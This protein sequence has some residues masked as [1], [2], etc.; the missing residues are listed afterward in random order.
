MLN[1][2][3]RGNYCYDIG[4]TDEPVRDWR[5]RTAVRQGTSDGG[6]LPFN[7]DQHCRGETGSTRLQRTP[8]P[9]CWGVCV[10][11]S[12]ALIVVCSTHRFACLH[13]VSQRMCPPPR[14]EENT[15]QPT[16][17]SNTKG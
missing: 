4:S 16:K 13:T 15:K 12:C 7:P 17:T 3:S 2:S 6:V 11:W 10:R 14:V 9:A 1:S 5:Q 8:L